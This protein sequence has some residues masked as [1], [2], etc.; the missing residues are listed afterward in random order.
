MG[1]LLSYLKWG[2]SRSDPGRQLW[3]LP[4]EIKF[5]IST[6][7]K[8][9][10]LLNKFIEANQLPMKIVINNSQEV[11]RLNNKIIQIPVSCV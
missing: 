3:I 6:R 2:R 1:L 10:T 8:Q 9:L 4:I 11:K 5:G 7:L